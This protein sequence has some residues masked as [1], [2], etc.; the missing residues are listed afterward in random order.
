M[1]YDEIIMFL[2]EQDKKRVKQSIIVTDWDEEDVM[3]YWELIDD[4]MDMQADFPVKRYIEYAYLDN[5]EG[6]ILR[7]KISYKEDLT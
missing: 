5:E 4:Y 2:V 1:N 7:S 6:D 3:L